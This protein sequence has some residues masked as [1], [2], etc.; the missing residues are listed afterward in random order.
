MVNKKDDITGETTFDLDGETYRLSFSVNAICA[1][2]DA[3][4]EGINQI[5][6]SMT[7]QESLRFSRVR[8]IFWAGLRDHR[9]EIAVED[10]GRVMTRLGAIKALEL[11]AAAFGRAFPEVDDNVPLARKAKTRASTGRRS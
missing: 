6:T 5:A 4:D 3:L 8:T 2:E 11:V 10:A 7:N 1:L 9:P